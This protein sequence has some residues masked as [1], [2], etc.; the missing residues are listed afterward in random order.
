MYQQ[1]D[2]DT[3]CAI[4]TPSGVGGIAV[5]RVSGSDAFN[6][7]DTIWRGR[8]LTEATSH[9]AHL[10]DI[11]DPEN[12]EEPLDTALATVFRAPRSFTGENVVEISVHGSRWIQ[13]EL[14]NLLIRQGCRMAEAG[15]F[16]RRAFAN[17][18]LDLAQAEAVADVIAASSRS[19]HRL[20][21]S[22]MRGD[23]SKHISELRDQLVEIASLLELELD[24]SEEDVEFASRSHLKNLAEL[25]L[26]KISTLVSSFSTGSA[27][28]DGVPVAIIGEPN[29]GKSTLLNVLLADNRAIVSDIPGTTRDTIEDT[30]E[31][32]GVLYRFIDTAG[33]RETTDAVENLG[34]ERSYS[35]ISKAR[36]V[37]WLV[38]PDMSPERFIDFRKSISTHLTDGAKLIIAVN[39]IDT[40]VATD[41][42]NSSPAE[43]ELTRNGLIDEKH[44]N[45]NSADK[46]SNEDFS[47]VNALLA[48]FAESIDSPEPPLLHI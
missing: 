19:A 40:L 37:I 35:A 27:L 31:I 11:I 34:I 47:N 18:R 16:T 6:I 28:K 48:K 30:M 24:F 44:I 7:V 43:N 25:L 3:I 21:A 9:T 17:G 20:A 23:F 1:F 13:R 32:D 8:R 22:Q 38:T 10:G 39:K 45:D 5:V 29:A 33:I 15:E 14:L 42:H 36:I 26:A 12:Q 4:S 46:I 2:S 41:G